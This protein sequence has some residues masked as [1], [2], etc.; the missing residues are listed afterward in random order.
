VRVAMI[1]VALLLVGVGCAGEAPQEERTPM[2]RRQ[3][4]S[5]L[6]ASGLPG[7]GGVGRAMEIADSAAARAS[8]ALPESP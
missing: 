7:A 8:R 2:T 4:D 3:R 5:T 1:I 6:A